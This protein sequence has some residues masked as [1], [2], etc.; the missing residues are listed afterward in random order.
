MKFTS[1]AAHCCAP[2]QR[3]QTTCR[4]PLLS[5]LTCYLWRYSPLFVEGVARQPAARARHS[6]WSCSAQ[7]VRRPRAALSLSLSFNRWLA[8]AAAAAADCLLSA[9]RACCIPLGDR[10]ARARPQRQVQ[11][12]R[13]TPTRQPT[14]NEPSCRLLAAVLATAATA[15]ASA[16]S[17]FSIERAYDGRARYTREGKGSHRLA[18]VDATAAA[19]MRFAAAAQPLIY[20]CRRRSKAAM[21]Q[22][23][24]QERA[25]NFAQWRNIDGN[26]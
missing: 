21:I 19:A 26:S 17:S 3:A 10:V 6:R 11:V 24:A 7:R 23:G 4:P 5:S 22:L 25:C 16:S 20:Y 8:A 9:G 14:F 12:A 13:Q 2:A 1:S 15:A 18:G